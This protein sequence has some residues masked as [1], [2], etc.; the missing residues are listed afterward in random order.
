MNAFGGRPEDY[1]ELICNSSFTELKSAKDE[2]AGRLF[3]GMVTLG[4]AT[5]AMGT[6]HTNI[7]SP[8][9]MKKYLDKSNISD[10]ESLLGGKQDTVVLTDFNN[11]DFID[12]N[13][14]KTTV[15]LP[16]SDTNVL[17]LDKE[18]KKLYVLEVN[19]QCGISEDEDFTSIGAILRFSDKSFSQL[20]TE[21]INDAVARTP[22]LVS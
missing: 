16:S 1:S 11:D 4:V 2:F 8:L 12:D 9:A 18:T 20:V 10:F 7:F 3:F 17:L 5:V 13:Q 14:I 22:V 19:A 15:A 21:I 6:M